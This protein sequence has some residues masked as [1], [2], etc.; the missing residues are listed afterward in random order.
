MSPPSSAREGR[1]P[2]TGA[3]SPSDLAEVSRTVIRG[4]VDASPALQLPAPTR[5]APPHTSCLCFH[6][7]SH[8]TSGVSPAPC[9]VTLSLALIP[10]PTVTNCEL[11]GRETGAWQVVGAQ[12]RRAHE[13]VSACQRGLV[14]LGS[15]GH[16]PPQEL[17]SRPG[18]G[19]G[20]SGLH[21]AACPRGLSGEPSAQAQ[22]RGGLMAKLT[23]G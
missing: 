17:C 22:V 10:I 11:W 19:S 8:P 9:P 15:G 21:G 16:T 18:L 4:E 2:R 20:G 7:S 14:A 3:G 23:G 12:G 1:A 5:K 6:L 13:W